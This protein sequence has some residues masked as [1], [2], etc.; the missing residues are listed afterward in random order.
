MDTGRAAT[1]LHA[2]VFPLDGSTHTLPSC[3]GLVQQQAADVVRL[4]IL[5]GV[6]VRLC[7]AQVTHP[8]NGVGVAEVGQALHCASVADA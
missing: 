1:R 7:V 4:M 3:A 5:S 6:D 8:A 2:H